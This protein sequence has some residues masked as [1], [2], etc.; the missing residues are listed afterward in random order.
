MNIGDILARRGDN[1]VVTIGPEATIR[2]LVETLAGHN[3]GACVVSS[4]GTAIEGI[5]SERDVVRALVRIEDLAAHTVRDIMTPLV[6]TTEP[7]MTVDE[8]MS[9]MTEHRFRHAPVIEHDNLIGI[10]SIGDAV[11]HRIDEL[12]WER[13]QLATYVNS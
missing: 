3:I 13:D 1:T 11:K 9:L 12:T 6:F 8:V 7:S 4:D 10:I 2:R 5:V